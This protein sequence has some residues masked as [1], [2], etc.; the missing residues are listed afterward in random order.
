MDRN[1]R[2]MWDY[3]DDMSDEPE[4]DPEHTSRVHHLIDVIQS[5]V[6]PASWRER[7]GDIG[8]IREINGQLVITQ[9][10]ANQRQ[11]GGL[12]DKLREQRAIQI[13]VADRCTA[14]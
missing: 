14:H 1:V 9:N 2:R 7:G 3:G 11:I 4:G 6:A 12:L 10:S 8:T 5:T 13:S